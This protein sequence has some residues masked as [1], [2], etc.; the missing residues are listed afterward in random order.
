MGNRAFV[1]AYQ[2]RSSALGRNHRDLRLI[3]R[4]AAAQERGRLVN[5]NHFG[6]KGRFKRLVVGRRLLHRCKIHLAS[7]LQAFDLRLLP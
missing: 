6:P 3:D 7:V 2:N 5:Q 4:T 1:V